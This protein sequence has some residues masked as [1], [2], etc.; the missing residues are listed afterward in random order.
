[1]N[2]IALSREAKQEL[3]EQIK[4]YFLTERDESI[5]DF[6]AENVLRFILD[7]IGPA[8][9]NQAIE[10]AYTLMNEKTE[11]LFGLQKRSR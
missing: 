4:N 1:M 3:I 6:H 5:S 2:N 7:T 11:E 10:D 9:Y 8:I